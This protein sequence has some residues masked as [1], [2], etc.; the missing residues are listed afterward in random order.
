MSVI[1]Q[2]E[3]NKILK[4]IQFNKLHNPGGPMV[5]QRWDPAIPP[6]W[7]SDDIILGLSQARKYTVPVNPFPDTLNY[8]P[9]ILEVRVPLQNCM[10][11][12]FKCVPILMTYKWISMPQGKWVHKEISAKF[13]Y[14]ISLIP[15]LSIV[16]LRS[17]GLLHTITFI[18]VLRVRLWIWWL[19]TIVIWMWWPVA[20]WFSL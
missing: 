18:T 15:V 10:D 3:F 12:F 8:Y 19:G 2:V 14:I 20:L 13:P 9:T 4:N 17:C 7:Y 5:I 6:W 1:F 16:S 11:T